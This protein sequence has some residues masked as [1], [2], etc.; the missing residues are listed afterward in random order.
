MLIRIGDC[1]VDTEQIQAVRDL[2]VPGDETPT[3]EIILP[4]ACC[5]QVE[6]T[7]DEAEAALIDAGM[8]ENPY[9][10]AVGLTLGEEE[11]AELEEL[12]EHGYEYIAR[13]ADGKLNA[14]KTDPLQCSGYFYPRGAEHAEPVAGAFSFIENADGVWSIPFLLAE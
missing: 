13:D 12:Y 7:M 5:F 4:G 10:E 8:I 1:F 11:L 9:P 2:F 6:A 3:L 14:F